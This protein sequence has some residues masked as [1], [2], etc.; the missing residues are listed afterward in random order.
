MYAFVRSLGIRELLAR[1]APMLVL[2]LAIAEF[3]YKFGSFL[4]ESVAFLATWFVLDAVI[5]FLL[6]RRRNGNDE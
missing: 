5:D 6:I 4:L 1:Q 2:S 3:F